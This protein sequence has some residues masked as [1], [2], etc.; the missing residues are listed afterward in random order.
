MTY[1]NKTCDNAA[2]DQWSA[3]YLKM[4]C[5]LTETYG[6]NGKGVVR[7]GVCKYAAALAQE[8][9]NALLAAGMK[10]NLKTFFSCGFGLPCGDRAK[11][12][13]IRNTEQEMFVTIAACPYAECWKGDTHEIG[14]MFCEEYYHALVHE[15]TS[16]K[17]QINLGYTMLNGRDDSCRLS[18]YLR[19]ANVPAPQRA[20]CFPGFDPECGDSAECLDYTPDYQRQK[21]TLVKSFLSAA[22]ERMGADCVELVRSTVKAYGKETGDEDLLAALE[23]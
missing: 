2:Q 19:P 10:T 14:R 4:A 5:V 1:M 17:A 22:E 11:H 8:R 12:E 15:G 21:H 9:K 18:V 20:Q 7:E 16:E 23:A 13:W 6:V 3:L